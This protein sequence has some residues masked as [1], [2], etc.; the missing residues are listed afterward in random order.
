MVLVVVIGIIFVLM[1]T[2]MN[3][4]AVVVVYFSEIDKLIDKFTDLESAFVYCWRFK[5]VFHNFIILDTLPLFSLN[6]R[7]ALQLV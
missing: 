1:D 3:V 6:V 4:I 7:I 5:V 2:S